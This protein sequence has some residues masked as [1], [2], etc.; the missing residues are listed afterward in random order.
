M[1]RKREEKIEMAIE[2]LETI[3]VLV[4]EVIGVPLV[5]LKKYLK[6]VN[7]EFKQLN[8]LLEETLKTQN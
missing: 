1:E 7:E 4:K 2:D 8:Q 5:D 3:R 6:R